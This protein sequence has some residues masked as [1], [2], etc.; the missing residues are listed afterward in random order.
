M[1]LKILH[2][3]VVFSFAVIAL[4]LVYMQIIRGQY[5]FE[6]SRNNR[7]RVVPLEGW[8]GRIKDRN[9]QVLAENRMSYKVMIT[10]QFVEDPEKIFNFLSG[11]LQRTK[12]DLLKVYQRK[13]TAPFTPVII[14]ED[15]TKQQ[16][17]LIEENKF[18][19][20]SLL[21]EEGFTRHYP[22]AANSSHVLGYVGKISRSK[23][24]RLKEYG[25]SPQSIVGYSGIEEYYDSFLKGEEGGL[26]VEVNSRGQQVKLLSLREP[27]QGQDIVLTIDS[28]IQQ[29]AL[30][31]MNNQPGA[32]VMMDMDSGEILAL[33]SSPAFDPNTFVDGR[34]SDNSTFLFSDSSAP[35]L[36]RAIK[37]A[38]PPGSV[39][40]I[41]LAVCA[42]ENK[43]ISRNTSFQC[44]G[45]MELGGNS[46]RCTHVHGVQ[47][48]I[49]SIAHSCNVYF[50][51]IGQMVGPEKI[52][53]FARMFGLGRPTNVDLPYEASGR[54]PHPTS[55][56][57]RKKWYG[58]DTLN[59]SIGQGALL[60]TPLQLT[61]MMATIGN[62]GSEAQPHMIKEIGGIPVDK[63]AY[64]RQILEPG[65]YK[66][67][68]RG[69][70]ATVTDFSGTAHDLD[71][72]GLHISGK[73]GTAQSSAQ[74]D[75]H[76]WF[77]GYVK[78]DKIKLA[79]C[80]FLEHGGSSH[81]AVVIAQDLLLRMKDKG[82]L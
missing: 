58:G 65:I 64:K 72:S 62:S 30:E 19:F 41:P 22:L 61:R 6:L 45:S 29:M 33:N 78:T 17:F 16:A 56:A 8:R 46:F 28:R 36:N 74:K 44:R 50:F 12:S 37:G 2:I 14:A 55:L 76:A 13:K 53:Q 57:G 27:K 60:T 82:I 81:N 34:S 73:T 40:K 77:V 79:F 48:L 24:D 35:M 43:K 1:R 75:H 3:L 68:H 67:I 51:H 18:L 38:Y 4:Q 10:P 21:V 42:L 32:V 66:D 31:L 69:L 49:E 80:V 39:F 70:R 23:I 20:P 54:V 26:Q 59:L 47:N 11:V 71:I 63:Y 9:G 52:T 7:I 25:Y 5:Y 15:I